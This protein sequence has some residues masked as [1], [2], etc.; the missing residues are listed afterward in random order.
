MK[1]LHDEH[2]RQAVDH[3]WFERIQFENPNDA[4]PQADRKQGFE[5]VHQHALSHSNNSAQLTPATIRP[6]VNHFPALPL[7]QTAT[8][9]VPAVATMH[10]VLGYLAAT[11][12]NASCKAASVGKP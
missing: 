1:Q 3:V 2:Q 4:I 12:S 11:A 6:V 5:K 10:V 8:I 9:T 7:V